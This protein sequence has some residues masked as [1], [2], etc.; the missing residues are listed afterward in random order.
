MILVTVV[1][2][3]GGIIGSGFGH[4]ESKINW[5]WEFGL[6]KIWNQ[7]F[8][9]YFGIWNLEAKSYQP[10]EPGICIKNMWKLKHMICVESEHRICG[11]WNPGCTI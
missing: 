4:L 11:M 5:K 7:E 10:Q 2:R 6:E 1:V 8:D 9:F 3:D